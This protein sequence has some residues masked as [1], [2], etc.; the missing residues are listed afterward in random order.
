MSE[1][2]RH[3]EH[4]LS[5]QALDFDGIMWVCPIMARELDGVGDPDER[6]DVVANHFRLSMWGNNG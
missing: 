2:R 3:P 4:C 1:V 6:T 5:G